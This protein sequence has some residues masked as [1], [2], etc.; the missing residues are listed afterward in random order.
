MG[1]L[2][3][4]GFA[5]TDIARSKAFYEKQRAKG[6][7]HN[8]AVRSL[9]FKWIRIIHRC[10]LDR[11]RYDESRYLTALQKRGSPLL[12]FAVQQAQ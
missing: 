8:A 5:V 3:H 4:I 11:T 6:S 10:W 9:A 2:D 12:A 7:S 1:T